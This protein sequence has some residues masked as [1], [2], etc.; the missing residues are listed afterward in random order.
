MKEHYQNFNFRKDSLALLEV[1]DAIIY[2][3][4]R[5]GYVLTVRQLYYQLVARDVIPNTE[6][7]YKNTVD[8]VN[9]GRLAGL[10]DWDA[11]EDRTRGFLRRS[12]WDSGKHIL[13]SA[14]ASFHMDMWEDQPTRVFC[15]VEK[16]ALSGVLDP[17]CREWDV[18]LLPARGYPS[19]SV[20]RQFAKHDLMGRPQD[21][22]ILHLGD[23][24]PS[25]ID[26]TRDLEDRL[27]LLSRRAGFEM[28]RIALT[29][30]QIEDQKPPPNPAK[31]TDAR[32]GEYSRLYGDESWELDA[33]RPQFIHG[34]VASHVQEVVD[35]E[36]WEAREAE[37]EAIRQRIVK[38][39]EDF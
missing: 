8:L 28:R 10:L 22:L 14:A 12:A 9:K 21:I 25:G 2:E 5:A 3:Y 15:V 16:E 1:I 4:S 34:L 27:S 33:L 36:L 24:D 20:L 35:T 23:H 37:I 26:M 30:E 18:P 6:R 39:A 38:L 31:T 13:E 11:I 29:M 7:S 19:A 17:V 32:F